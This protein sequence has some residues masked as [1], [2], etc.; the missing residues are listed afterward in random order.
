MKE[1]K[2]TKGKVALV[3]DEDYDWLMKYKWFAS[4]SSPTHVCA[5]R[6]GGFRMHR[7]IM[8]TPIGMEVDHIDHNELNNQK[9]NL[10]N[11]TRKQNAHN[12]R[13][14]GKYKG[15]YINKGYIMSRIN[16]EQNIIYLGSFNSEVEA[17]KAYNEAAVKYF[18]EFAELNTIP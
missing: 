18:G 14:V 3:D 11:C 9:Y 17:A 16:Y 7:E 8:K 1:I 15:V 5:R 6:S 4:F 10:R 13:K 12:Q 2:L